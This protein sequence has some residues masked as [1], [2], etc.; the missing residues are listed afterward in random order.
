LAISYKRTVAPVTE[1]ITLNEAKDHLE[2]NHND[3][4]NLINMLIKTAREMGEHES[5]RSFFTQTIVAQL[6]DFPTS[7]IELIYGPVQSVTTLKYYDVDNVQQTWSNANYRVDIVSKIAKV[8]AVNSWPE[9]YDRIDAIEV[10]YVAGYTEVAD[11]PSTDKSGMLML[12]THLFENRQDVVVGSQVNMMP[13]SS[14]FLFRKNK[15]YHVA[16]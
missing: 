14:Q 1:P 10:T 13:Q 2:I 11:I 9:V 12:L 6:D 8:E 4:D 16:K 15:I 3:K 7:N 5:A